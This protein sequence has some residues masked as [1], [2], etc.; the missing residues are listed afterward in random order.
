MRV[1]E[2]KML[3]AI[4][5]KKNWESGNTRVYHT[6]SGVVEVYLHN[7]LIARLYH[8]SDINELAAISLAGW[9]SKTTISRLNALS[10]YTHI[11]IKTCNH[12]PY[13]VVSVYDDD[14]EQIVNHEMLLPLH[15]G[16]WT[17]YDDILNNNVA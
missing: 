13:G 12:S 7:N 11:R 1:I 2:E 5:N 3:K 4:K 8:N 14:I 6:P 9:N 15:T 17:T 10:Y 16:S